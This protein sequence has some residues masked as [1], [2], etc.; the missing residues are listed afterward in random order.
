M[1]PASLHD[2]LNKSNFVIKIT[3]DLFGILTSMGQLRQSGILWT[4]ELCLYKSLKEFRFCTGAILTRLS[5]V[6]AEASRLELKRKRRIKQ[7]RKKTS[8][9]AQKTRKQSTR[10]RKL[11]LEK[12][13]NRKT[14]M[15]DPL[16]VSSTEGHQHVNPYPTKDLKYGVTTEYNDLSTG[17]TITAD[18]SLPEYLDS[19][20]WDY[21]NC[22]SS[23][24]R[25]DNDSGDLLDYLN[26]NPLL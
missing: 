12:Q 2:N 7:C 16:D 20:V 6:A 19:G 3:T 9:A 25:L 4:D 15:E 13:L 11:I 1:D 18:D 14:P 8:S 17:K 26:P 23:G 22:W 10:N 21:K 5:S 24:S